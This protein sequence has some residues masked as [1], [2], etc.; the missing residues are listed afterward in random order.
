MVQNG[1]LEYVDMFDSYIHGEGDEDNVIPE[2]AFKNCTNLKSIIL[3][4]KTLALGYESLRVL[5]CFCCK[6]TLLRIRFAV[7]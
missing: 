5:N 3:P 4:Q 6:V 7:S 2:E 1:S